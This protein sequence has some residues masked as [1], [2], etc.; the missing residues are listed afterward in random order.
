MFAKNYDVGQYLLLHKHT[1]LISIKMTNLC[2]GQ[3]RDL[4]AFAIF[5]QPSLKLT[6]CTWHK[7]AK[8][9]CG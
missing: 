2:T 8:T 9:L 6:I 4:V 5:V 7:A 3:N 1:I